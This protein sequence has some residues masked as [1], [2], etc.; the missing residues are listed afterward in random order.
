MELIGRED[1]IQDYCNIADGLTS[2]PLGQKVGGFLRAGTGHG[3][4]TQRALGGSF[5]NVVWQSF[6]PIG[7]YHS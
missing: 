7:P 5:V 6:L 4:S 3:K 2:P 1:F